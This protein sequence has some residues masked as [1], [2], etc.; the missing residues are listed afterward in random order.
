MNHKVI[1]SHLK[2]YASLYFALFYLLVCLLPAVRVST[3]E[4][5]SIYNLPLINIIQVLIYPICIILIIIA[6]LFSESIREGRS[7]LVSVISVA[8]LFFLVVMPITLRKQIQLGWPNSWLVADASMMLFGYYLL[9]CLTI[10]YLL[11]FF[12]FMRLRAQKKP[13]ENDD[14]DE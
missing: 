7:I 8:N 10:A 13:R 4:E 9:Y 2:K 11:T 3:G 6:G 14:V 5:F 12:V 1:L